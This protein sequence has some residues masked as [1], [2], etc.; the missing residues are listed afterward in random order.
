MQVRMSAII[1]ACF[2]AL[3]ACGGSGGGAAAP[4]PTVPNCD[5]S[6]EY[7][8][9]I[10]LSANA[11]TDNQYWPFSVQSGVR[12]FNVHYSRL[13]DE[14]KALEMLGILE[15]SWAVQIDTLG[16]SA[17][18]DDG[19]D[20]GPDGRYDVFIWRGIDGAFVDAIA[21]NPLTPHDDY[22]TY[23]AIS[24]A[25]STG[26]GLLDTTLAH[27][28]NH[29]AQASDDWWESALFF[30]MS[31]TF[32]EAL[33]YPQEDDYF[34]TLEDFQRR[35]EW[36]IF[37]VDNYATW[38]MYGAAMY[39]HFLSE[40]YY[41]NDPAFIARLWRG[42]RSTPTGNRPD[43]IDAI[44]AVLL[45][46]RG[47]TLDETI[48]EFM[49]WRWFV[50]QFDDGLHFSKGANWP[51]PVSFLDID[52]STLPAAVDLDA[53]MFGANYLRLV[54][55]TGSPLSIKIELSENDAEVNWHL[56]TVEGVQIVSMMTIPPQS[57]EVMV[58]IALP[59]NEV[60]SNTLTFANHT[61]SLTMQLL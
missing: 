29:A 56:S 10:P 32:V 55:N 27:E 34:F 9:A 20:C 48:I 4:P 23:M 58:A 11:C 6:I 54:N 1:T 43:Y 49:Q 46:D 37:Y 45:A 8:S 28:F 17:P 12:P 36:S 38:H 21:E 26:Q 39:L 19:G 25:G 33:T 61:A 40:R 18:L 24:I 22:T 47:V 59:V 16:F 50:A 5:S 14:T 42:A 3:S 53:M 30:E 31:A 15:V 51:T 57:T 7:C 60:Y 35:P 52:P 13:G 2:A 41:P 44:R